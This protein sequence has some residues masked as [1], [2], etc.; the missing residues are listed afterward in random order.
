MHFQNML[1]LQGK[2]STIQIK[3]WNIYIVQFHLY[4]LEHQA[5]DVKHLRWTYMLD[6]PKT[7]NCDSCI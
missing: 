7:S 3:I 4:Y 6:K 1:S 2:F 5:M